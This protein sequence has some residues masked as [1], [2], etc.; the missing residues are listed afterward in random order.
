M[1]QAVASEITSRSFAEFETQNAKSLAQIGTDY[2]EVE[3]RRFPDEVLRELKRLTPI[4]LDEEA[5]GDAMFAKVLDSYRRY[6]AQLAPWTDISL[7]SYL[8]ATDL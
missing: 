3:I 6:S 5:E 7:K 2:P 1:I 8:A 4:V